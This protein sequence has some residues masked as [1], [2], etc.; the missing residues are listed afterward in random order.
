MTA[1]FSYARRNHL[2]F[3][4]CTLG[5]VF[6][7]FLFIR[8]IPILHTAYFSFCKYSLIVRKPVFIGFANYHNLLQ[9]HN[10]TLALSNTVIYTVVCVTVTLSLALF[11]AVLLRRIE[12][13]SPIYEMIYFIPVITPW[14]PASVIWRWLYDPKYGILNY[15]F[16]LIGLPPQSW[17]QQPGQVLYAIILVS[18]WKTLG[19]YMVIYSVG[20]KNIP[21]VYY[22]AAQVD[23]ATALQ[24]FRNVTLPL[25]KPI[26]LFSIIMAVIQFFNVFTV[27]YVLSSE[28]QGSPSYECRVLVWEIYRNAFYY[29]K[30]GYAS[31]EAI[32]L[33]LF[34]M[35]IIGVQFWIVRAD[36]E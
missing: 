16:S 14:V 29:N 3:V 26:F 34:V 18:I 17:L 20:L 25:L 1:F 13:F 33:L 2:L 35:T 22:E 15:L 10:F 8:I 4:L 7:L 19:Y 32:V 31:A 21:Y 30:M 11:F 12:R 28:A 36:V 6:V 23:G 5:P 27:A 9:D 24:E